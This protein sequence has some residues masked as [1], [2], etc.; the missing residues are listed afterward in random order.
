MISGG[1]RIIGSALGWATNTPKIMSLVRAAAFNPITWI[2]GASIATFV[3][4][5]SQIAD[6][7]EKVNKREDE[8]NVG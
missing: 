7:I 5:G 3:A 4:M 1:K 2:A 8:L 6:T